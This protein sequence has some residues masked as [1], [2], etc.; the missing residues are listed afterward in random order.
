MDIVLIRNYIKRYINEE[1]I[2]FLKIK[3]AYLIIESLIIPIWK[4]NL[5]NNLVPAIIPSPGI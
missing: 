5:R 2:D 4:N 1:K 3:Y